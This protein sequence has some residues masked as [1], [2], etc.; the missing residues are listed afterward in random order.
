MYQSPITIQTIPI[1]RE[2]YLRTPGETIRQGTY[3][4][5][6]SPTKSSRRVRWVQ[7]SEWHIQ[8]DFLNF[9]NS[10][11]NAEKQEC[12]THSIAVEGYRAYINM[13]PD[14]TNEDM[15][16]QHL[17]MKYN[18]PHNLAAPPMTT[19]HP[20]SRIIRR[21]GFYPTIGNPDYLFVEPQN[22]GF[23]A[24]YAVM[25]L[26][27]FWKVTPQGLLEVLNGTSPSFH[28]DIGTAPIN[29]YHSGRLAMEQIY[30]YMVHNAKRFGILTTVNWWVFLRRENGGQL[31]MTQP[32]DCQTS[33][34]P[35][36]FTILQAL[37]YFSTLSVQHGH[38]PETDENGNPVSIELADS[39]Y[40]TAA[41]SVAGSQPSPQSPGNSLVIYPLQPGQFYTLINQSLGHSILLEP[42]K[43]ENSCGG[44]TF[45]GILMPNN[46]HVI[47]KLWDGYKFQ[48]DKRDREV[49]I[50]MKLQTLWGKYTP[51]LICSTNI[52]FCYGIIMT[53]VKVLPIFTMAHS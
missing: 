5:T 17:D 7:L 47:V 6:D 35:Y 53:E 26:K 42:W 15:L 36:S 34:P 33:S 8:N 52:D 1:T 10:L 3:T 16:S 32:L 45:H 38:L 19:L 28:V 22:A 50:Y 4:Q 23:R 27:T 14:P 18:Q 20:H 9:W 30:G 43:P 29:E 25:E 46:E 21:D 2:Q 37:Y 31:Y 51:Q 12:I 11:P 24:L 41:P 44:K 40:P 13:L 39:T 49:E 48:S